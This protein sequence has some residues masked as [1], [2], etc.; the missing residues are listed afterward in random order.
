MKHAGLSSPLPSKESVRI[1]RANREQH[2]HIWYSNA[3]FPPDVSRYHPL[4]THFAPHEFLVCNGT[5]YDIRNDQFKRFR[6]R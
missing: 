6:E 3:A 4:L 5:K 2:Y 1:T